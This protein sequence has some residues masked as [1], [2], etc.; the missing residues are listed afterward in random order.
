[1]TI[2]PETY[3]FRFERLLYCPQLI[4][5]NIFS[6]LPWEHTLA[7]SQVLRG[8]KHE[9]AQIEQNTC[10]LFPS[11]SSPYSQQQALRH[12][13]AA[14]DSP[15]V[16][17]VFSEQM[18]FEPGNRSRAEVI[19]L[20]KVL[21]RQAHLMD[22]EVPESITVPSRDIQSLNEHRRIA[23]G[24]SRVN[25]FKT[26]VSPPGTFRLPNE[27]ELGVQK[28]PNSLSH[29]NAYIEWLLN[30]CKRNTAILSGI[31][32]FEMNTL[33]CHF[34]TND[35]C[36]FPNLRTLR[37]NAKK[38]IDIH[39]DISNIRSLGSIDL[40]HNLLTQLP[41]NFGNLHFLHYLRI[42]RN[43]L[44]ALP[45][46][47]GN[48]TTLQ[49]LDL[50]ANQLTDLP[51][52]F[53]KLSSLKSLSLSDN[54][55]TALPRSFCNLD[56]LD[57][58]FLANNNLRELPT[59]FGNF[60]S[61]NYLELHGNKLTTLPR[62]FGNLRVSCH[63][64]LHDNALSELP[65]EFSDICSIKAVTL[66]HNQLTT[67]APQVGKLTTLNQLFLTHNRLTT[68][69][70]SIGSLHALFYL[71][72]D[73]ITLRDLPI[74]FGNLTRL[75]TLHLDHNELTTLPPTFCNLR[76]LRDLHLNVNFITDL[77]ENFSKLTSLKMR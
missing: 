36:M 16:W 39:P 14:V 20:V 76:R 10:A 72:L 21:F 56:G 4:Q 57:S 26:V 19:H 29:I 22:K 17:S 51:E 70:S 8:Y 41:F 23:Y 35:V 65:I 64:T 6:K 2:S 54:M 68:L 59:D 9:N 62:S 43:K 31:T 61:L 42:A 67:F 28:N 46:S 33:T 3:P 52:S 60:T 5:E 47:F 44:T 63:L 7:W 53:G 49:S 1:M 38:I 69:P 37:C 30:L 71:R 13:K 32:V 75:E 18:G 24:Q 48:L 25:I 45:D 66:G 15:N 12:I 50:E 74:E 73:Y 58:L 40:S 55:L 34:L 11:G 27:L 77:P